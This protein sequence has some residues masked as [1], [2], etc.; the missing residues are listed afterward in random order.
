[1]L[2]GPDGKQGPC[3]D[4]SSLSTVIYLDTV[5]DGS[6]PRIQGN[7]S[8]VDLSKQ[9]CTLT[10]TTPLLGGAP[11]S[12][13]VSTLPGS[14]VFLLAD[15]LPQLSLDLSR[16]GVLTVSAAR[17]TSRFIGTIPVD[18]SPLS[19]S[20][21]IAAY[22]RGEGAVFFTQAIY[23]RDKGTFIQSVLGTPSLVVQID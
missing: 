2:D 8:V 16:F 5:F 20:V 4:T 18:G 19:V 1:M 11:T 6:F 10:T 9:A 23:L 22:R 7:P 14:D 21:P 15:E 17:A 12:V 3:I 13:S